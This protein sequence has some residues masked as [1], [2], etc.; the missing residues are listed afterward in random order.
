[1]AKTAFYSGNPQDN[2]IIKPLK[3]TNTFNFSL[4]IYNATIPAEFGHIF[5]VSSHFGCLSVFFSLI[6][7]SVSSLNGSFI[8]VG[9]KFCLLTR[10]PFDYLMWVCFSF[11]T[12]SSL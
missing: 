2:A 4:V 7:N 8:R 10:T 6:C 12:R 11:L 3:I 9:V 1:M 5:T